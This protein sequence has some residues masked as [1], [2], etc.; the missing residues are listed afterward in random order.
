MSTFFPNAQ[1][2]SICGGVFS[3]VQGDQYN[4]YNGHITTQLISSS[5]TDQRIAATQE[6]SP[7]STTM[8]SHVNRN[9]VNQFSQREEKERTEFSDYRN[10]KSGDFYRLE[11]VCVTKYRRRP[12]RLGER[13]NADRTF[14]TVKVI[15]TEGKFTSVT[16]SGP[17]ARRAFEEDFRKCSQTRSSKT[18]QVFAVDVGMVPSLLLWHGLVPISHFERS[19]ERVG[20]LYVYNLCRKLKCSERELWVDSARGLICRGPEGPLSY[21]VEDCWEV[22]TEELPLTIEMLQEDVFMRFLASQKSE[23][24][25]R[26][27][28]WAMWWDDIDI[29]VTELFDQPTIFS[30]LTATPIAFANN[31]WTSE[32]G[33]VEE[34]VLENGLTRFRLEED[35]TWLSLHLNLCARP[36]W[37]SQSSNIFQSRGISF[38]D[39]LS[40]YQLV[41]HRAS[42]EG[43]FGQSPSKSQ[44]RRQQPIYLFVYTPSRDLTE[45]KTSRLYFWSFH[46]DGRSRLSP[47][48]C[49]DFGLPIDLGIGIRDVYS[50]KTN[51][52]KQI[53]QYQRLR[54][55]DPTTTDYAQ[56]L[57][58]ND[59]I[60]QPID[61][62]ERFMQVYQEHFNNLD[63][64][65]T[66]DSSECLSDTM[67]QKPVDVSNYTA[68]SQSQ[69]YSREGEPVVS[70]VHVTNKHQRKDTGFGGTERNNPETG[71]RHKSDITNEHGLPMDKQHSRPVRPLPTRLLSFAYPFN[72]DS[73]EYSHLR[74][75]HQSRTP[76]ACYS[77]QPLHNYSP[78][79]PSPLSSHLSFPLDGTYIPPSIT[80]NLLRPSIDS[81]N[82]R[83]PSDSYSSDEDTALRPNRAVSAM[84]SAY[85]DP[86][87][88]SVNTGTTT[89]LVGTDSTGDVVTWSGK[90]LS[91]PLPAADAFHT[92]PAHN[93]TYNSM[94]T[95][96]YPS[97]STFLANTLYSRH[98]GGGG[99]TP[100]AH[101][102]G[103]PPLVPQEH[104]NTLDV[105]HHPSYSSSA[106]FPPATIFPPN[107]T[108]HAHAHRPSFSYTPHGHP[109][110]LPLNGGSPLAP[111]RHW[112][113][114][115][116]QPRQYID[117]F[118]IQPLPTSRNEMGNEF[119]ADE[120]GAHGW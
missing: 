15:G 112:S 13:P 55:F 84:D 109:I 56:H 50:W 98:S 120:D 107:S 116:G 3:H 92:E 18:A 25:D 79:L 75:A 62:S 97:N 69:I 108:V 88:Y 40:V 33:F 42:L 27:F 6:T 24:A 23:Q 74:Q 57:G 78:C 4:Y 11:D 58:Y 85:T 110:F 115:D 106:Y 71:F 76:P 21:I 28:L 44:R 16:Y 102:L 65:V 82:T 89:T 35:G 63:G 31:L 17:D 8:V 38:D 39:N 68:T 54:G 118:A 48:L 70:S 83:L 14:C 60:F 111:Q 117:G 53:H 72:I 5:S 114:P 119:S 45:G 64:S 100:H 29:D 113:V 87:L 1:N 2:T 99:A 93:P 73:L 7:T 67:D 59:H 49:L 20:G 51:N 91:A 46:K 36:A 37:L 86:S 32:S 104:W 47:E 43:Y 77:S 19:F 81:F 52:Y 94:P 9:Q 103:Y 26:V 22:E 105:Y 10:I 34:E 66:G 61:H 12:R 101:N 41:Y 96:G 95:V 80:F 90:S 30:T